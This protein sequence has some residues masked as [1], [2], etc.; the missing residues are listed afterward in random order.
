MRNILLGILFVLT[1][2]GCATHS[3]YETF[4]SR[5]REYDV[6]SIALQ[7]GGLTSDQIEAIRSTKLASD[8]PV[9]VSLILIKNGYIEP[10]QEKILIGQVVDEL[11]KYDKIARVIPVP[12]FLIPQKINFAKIQELGVR[13][14]SEYVLVLYLD[15]D[16][17][18]KWTVIIETEYE[19]ESIIDFLLVDSQT[20]AIIATDKLYSTVVYKANIF[21]PGERE[22]AEIEIFSEQ[23]QILGQRMRGLFK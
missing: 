8:F 2:I 12:N 1:T 11:Q 7:D 5:E 9:D 3:G 22:K 4:Q 10:D 6:G 15:S 23:G 14:M 13:T 17:L 21:K 19:I 18:F 16:T 20:T